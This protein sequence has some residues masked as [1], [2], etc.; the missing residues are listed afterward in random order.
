MLKLIRLELYKNGKSHIWRAFLSLIIVAIACT[1][2]CALILYDSANDMTG[3][4]L[5]TASSAL[6][7]IDLAELHDAVAI[8]HESNYITTSLI[9]LVSIFFVI[10]AGANYASYVVAD[11]KN[12]QIEQMYIYPV[13]RGKVLLAKILTASML[14]F[15]GAALASLLNIIAMRLI[16]DI[17]VSGSFI[18][19]AILASLTIPLLGLFGMLVGLWRKSVVATIVTSIIL[20]TVTSGNFGTFSLSNF[21]VIGYTLALIGLIATIVLIKKLKYADCLQ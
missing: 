14:T 4:L 10:F 19:Q 16:T 12:R 17:T 5:D 3:K 13:P 20:V 1:S 8:V 2:F 6:G 9:Q 15:L 11:F 21:P 7:S 18:L